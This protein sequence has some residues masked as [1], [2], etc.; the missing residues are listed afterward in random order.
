MYKIGEFSKLT[1]LSVPTLRYYDRIGLLV[2]EERS[3]SG[4]R[5]YSNRQ[6][7]QSQFIINMKSVGLTLDEIFSLMQHSDPAHVLP[8]LKKARHRLESDL[9]HIRHMENY[10]EIAQLHTDEM[11]NADRLQKG[12]LRGTFGLSSEVEK[13]DV[14]YVFEYCAQKIQKR[15]DEL[16]LRQN[17]GMRL[18]LPDPG[19]GHKPLLVLPVDEP[20]DAQAPA[21]LQWYEE[22]ET[23][24]CAV[25][26]KNIDY[27]PEIRRMRT[28]LRK[29]GTALPDKP[30]VIEFLLDPG[31]LM[32]L[33][34]ILA[35]V[36]LP[37]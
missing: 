1:G 26:K 15:R 33:N 9:E 17:S 19:G 37:L 29:E 16:G 24:S 32:N 30:A 14:E 8:V 3:S 13:L 34:K 2:P 6:L 23:V 12:V 10:Y 31:D 5:S 21:E 20:G 36:H 35:R 25:C 7:L 28:L 11:V 18:L 4:Y 22:K 27:R